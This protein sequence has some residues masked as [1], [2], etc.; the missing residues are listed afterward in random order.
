MDAINKGRRVWVI[1]NNDVE[2]GIVTSSFAHSGGVT[3]RVRWGD[4]ANWS[5]ISAYR[6]SDVFKDESAAC[7]ALALR[8]R[9]LA[10]EMWERAGQCANN[11]REP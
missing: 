5:G 4:R 8:L 2:K 9:K 1:R 10:D 3:Y 6:H 7:A 11:R